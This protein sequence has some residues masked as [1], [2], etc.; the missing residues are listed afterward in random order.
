VRELK[1]K[2]ATE[3]VE[4]LN[5]ETLGLEDIHLGFPGRF[6]EGSEIHIALGRLSPGDKLTMRTVE[7]SGVGLFDR[8]ELCVGRLS[9]K[10]EE[11]WI[12]RL[13]AV[14]EIRVLAMISRNAE[15]DV[16]QTRRDQYRVSEWEIPVVEVVFKDG[17]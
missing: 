17:C 14:R 5:Y 6:P 2:S 4:L 12:D 9:R 7:G 16:E 15:Q 1:Q 13:P 11:D 8:D 10:A 3:S